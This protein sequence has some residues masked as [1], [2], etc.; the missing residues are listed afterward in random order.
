V[1]GE[2][3]FSIDLEDVRDHV[4]NGHTYRERVPG[5][6]AHYLQFLETREIPATFFVVGQVAERY[7][8]LIREILDRGH[9]V[10]C[11]THTH[12]QL[13]RHTASTLTEDLERNLDALDRCGAERIEGFRAPTFSMSEQTRWVYEVLE[14]LGFRY[15]SSVLP[16]RNPLYGWPEFGPHPRRVGGILELPITLHPLLPVPLVGGIYFR[17]LPYPLIRSGVRRLVRRNAVL[18]SYFHPYDID[19]EQERFQHPDLA[20]SRLRNALMYVGRSKVLPRL[21]GLLKLCRFTNYRDY[22][23]RNP[24]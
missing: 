11:H 8:D 24:H 4:P 17:L 7:P 12:R 16:A 6:T 15:S 22:L 9:E 1:A 20:G 2:L 13:D 3:L 18:H 21:A 23:A 5:N 14:H 19:T 10:A